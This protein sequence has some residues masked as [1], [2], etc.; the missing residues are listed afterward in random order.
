MILYK[1][2]TP[3]TIFL[4]KNLSSWPKEKIRDFIKIK[5]ICVDPNKEGYTYRQSD[6]G[7]YYYK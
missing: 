2:Q 5:I 7:D 1:L 4:D 3:S 6:Y